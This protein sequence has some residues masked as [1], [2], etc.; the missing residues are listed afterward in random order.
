MSIKQYAV[1]WM[2]DVLKHSSH[3]IAISRAVQENLVKNHGVHLSKITTVHSSIIPNNA[4]HVAGHNEKREL[5]K[6]FGLEENRLL[7]FGCGIGMVFRKG[8]DLFIEIARI[9]RRKGFDDFHFYWIGDFDKKETHKR[10]G[11]WADYLTAMRKDGLDKYVTFLGVKDNPRE[12]FQAG[13]IFLSP[14]REE[15]F[16]LVVL[17]AAE[18]GLPTVCFADAGGT[19]EI[20]EQDAGFAVPYEDL[21]AMAAQVTLLMADDNLRARLGIRARQRLLSH[22]TTEQLTPRIFSTC[23]KVVS[24]R[25]AVS[26]IVPN[27]N[28]APYLQRR[29]DSIFDQ[30]FK[31]FEVIL[32]DDASTDHSM[33][34]LG[35]YA[36]CPDVRVIRNE[37]NSGSP[38][39][40]WLRGID[41]ARSDILWIAESDDA[42]EPQFLKTLLPM[43]RNPAVNLAYADSHVIDEN[44][45]VTGD[46]SNG[47]YLTSLSPTKWKRSYQV[48][49]LE[50]INDGLGVKNT[51]LNA[52]AALFR[53]FEFS[54]E[55][56]KTL[57]SM[58]I[59]GD[60]YFIVH[61]I[62]DGQ[63]RYQADK[64]NYHRRHSGSIIAKIVSGKKLNDFY[65]EFH[66]VQQFITQNY[67]LDNNF[68]SKW[69][70]YMQ[71]QWNDF[72]PNRPFDELKTYYPVD[73]MKEKIFSNLRRGMTLTEVRLI[74]QAT[75]EVAV[76]QNSEYE[77][78]KQ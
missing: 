24:K 31:D 49:A 51:I 25:P 17:E 69:D 7:I 15:P 50:E 3:F 2:G 14:S 46:Y 48:T 44:D 55:F 5:R 65:R 27:Y 12:Y 1:D 77:D 53:K 9:L 58:H 75:S 37:R 72:C 61:A 35:R 10:Y 36:N 26:V 11:I 23:R 64:L 34:V 74:T 8:A 30:T 56:R 59:A 62:K 67:K 28:H 68:Y 19:P 29:L 39:K 71:K 6:K 47:E 18:C 45:R 78:A 70:T 16:G 42:C 41:L 76:C 33:D 20:I 66:I 60:W 38:F 52:S 54:Q 40:Q 4:I 32:L 21:D 73:N 13:D 57:E 22:F 43:F 63:I